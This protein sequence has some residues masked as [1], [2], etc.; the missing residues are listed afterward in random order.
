MKKNLM[1]KI[2]GIVMAIVLFAVAPLFLTACGASANFTAVAKAAAKHYYKD[3]V[4]YENFANTTYVYEELTETKMTV[5]LEYKAN[6]E[7]TEKAKHNHTNVE[8]TDTVYT[9]SVVNGEEG[10]L[11]VV[12]DI[13]A[14]EA[15]KEYV[16]DANELLKEVNT[17]S[18]KHTVYKYS[19]VTEDDV[20]TYYL[21][22]EWEVKEDGEVVETAKKYRT[23]TESNYEDA[24]DDVLSHFN[25]KMVKEGYFEVTSIEALFYGSILQSEV[26]GSN[27]KVK[28]AYDTFEVYGSVVSDMSIKMEVGFENNKLGKIEMS[29]EMGNDT[30]TSKS[31]SKFHVEF[32]ANADTAVSLEGA[33]LDNYLYVISD[34]LPEVEMSLGD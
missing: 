34:D 5:E 8:T 10:K 28:L 21:T 17:T 13:N 4:D 12:L 6:A 11:S 27:A 16:V 32:S 31:T 25:R 14:T 3:H 23:Y 15:A 29:M 20:T 7:A 1:P 24:V 26:N 22:K 19:Y 18:S 33:T 2:L 30:Y 9:F